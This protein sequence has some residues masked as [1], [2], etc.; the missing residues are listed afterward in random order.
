[1]FF[2]FFIKYAF[3]TFFILGVNVFYIYGFKQLG[4]LKFQQINRYLIGIFMYKAINK[5][6][7]IMFQNFFVR[8]DEEHDHYTRASGNLSVQYARTNYRRFSLF[9][10]G[11]I[12]WNEIP[13]NICKVT[14]LV[15]FK[16]IWKKFPISQEE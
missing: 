3:L 7:P 1:M 15:T 11:P 9:C 6:L 12:I 13:F 4:I 5:L 8:R 2:I 16:K 14:M 10:K